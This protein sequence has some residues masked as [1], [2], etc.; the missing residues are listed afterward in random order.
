MHTGPLHRSLSAHM[1]QVHLQRQQP[2]TVPLPLHVSA[3]RPQPR[4]H[5]PVCAAHSEPCRTAL[6]LHA[7]CLASLVS[8]PA[9]AHRVYLLLTAWVLPSC[10]QHDDGISQQ[11][12]KAMHAIVDGRATADGCPV[13][14]TM[15]TSLDN[16]QCSLAKL[17]YIAGFEIADHTAH[18]QGEEGLKR[19][20][21]RHSA[22][23]HHAFVR[24][25]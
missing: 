25:L 19:A 21:C 13:T 8:R 17:L 22:A 9:K 2:R 4:R 12:A 5:A 16:N 11:T 1:V 3:E 20:A 6:S 10:L 18:C 23:S 7:R 14:A 15:F 24:T